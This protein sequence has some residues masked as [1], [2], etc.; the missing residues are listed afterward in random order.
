MRAFS[1]AW[2]LPVTWQRWRSHC[3]IRLNRKPH[4]ARTLHASFFY[5]LNRSYRRSKFYIARIET[6]TL[7]VLLYLDLDP[8]TFIYELDPY[9]IKT[10]LQIDN[11]LFASKLSKVIV[12]H[13]S[14]Y[15]Q[16][17]RF[18]GD[19]IIVITM[20][21]IKYNNI[22]TDPVFISCHGVLTVAV[23]CSWAI[24]DLPLLG[25][26]AYRV[27]AWPSVHQLW[28]ILY[29]GLLWDALF[30]LNLV[31]VELYCEIRVRWTVCPSITFLSYMRWWRTRPDSNKS[32][33]LSLNVLL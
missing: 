29:S 13:A 6:F 27:I 28:C 15:I 1:Y 7:Y 30:C 20:C 21:N 4:V 25:N 18:A 17:W 10:H 24:A 3:L 31:T 32:I 19:S 8:V 12:L 5:R 33:I 26:I 14:A 9:P 2:S 11:E 23:K 22:Y 16:P